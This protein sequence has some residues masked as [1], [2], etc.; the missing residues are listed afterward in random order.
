MNP[1]LRMLPAVPAAL[2]LAGC[3][4]S[5][6]YDD[7][8]AAKLA[9]I[10]AKLG[11]MAEVQKPPT[12]AKP[13]PGN[14]PGRIVADPAVLAKI[15]PLPEKPTDAEVA[16]YAKAVFDA[17]AKQTSFSSTDL[18]HAMIAKIGP[19]HLKELAPYL[20]N[21]YFRS[22][23]AALVRAEDRAE[24]LRMIPER[25]QLMIALPY[26]GIEPQAEVIAAI[27]ESA[28]KNSDP[29]LVFPI[30]PYL[31]MLA[32]DPK[33]WP[34]LVELSYT[35]PFLRPVYLK[36]LDGLDPAARQQKIRRLWEN[37]KN[38]KFANTWQRYWLLQTAA[39]SGII[40]AMGEWLATFDTAKLNPS[41]RKILD[42]LLPD[43][44]KIPPSELVEWFRTNRDKLRFDPAGSC[45]RLNSE[46]K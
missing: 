23:L 44:A 21:Y 43:A 18:Q 37:Q 3:C 42:K 15:K 19:G 46:T 6:S 31:P 30:S 39:G 1:L 10:D 25:P 45:Y 40:D 27:L 14:V 2:L 13:A 5:N 7:A 32:E 16:A 35:K 33:I 24:V 20:N 28:R 12:A 4:T 22:N 8:V 11:K 36:S 17:S 26:V 41:Q 38:L 34:E 9:D 29:D